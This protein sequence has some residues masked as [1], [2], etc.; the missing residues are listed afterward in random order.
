MRSRPEPSNLQALLSKPA[1]RYGLLPTV[2]ASADRAARE[3]AP[4]S[5]HSSD[6]L[7]FA[8]EAGGF[9]VFDLNL[10]AGGISGTPLF[11]DLIGLPGRDLNLTRE[12]WVATVHPED[13][14]AVVLAL[15][16]AIDSGAKYQCEYRTLLLNGEVR[17]LAGCAQVLLDDEGRPAHAIGT[18]CDI[19]ER[20]QLEEKL[21]YAT[22]SLNIAQTAAGLATF[23][24]NFGRNTR[25]CSEN[26]RTL[27]GIAPSTRLDD[28]DLLLSHVHP[29]D[30]ARL[31]SAPH[32]DDARRSDLSL[33]IPG[34]AR[35]CKPPLDRRE[36]HRDARQVR[37]DGADHGRHRRHQRLEA[38]RSG[39]GFR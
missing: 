23:D 29:D 8:Q 22:E 4:R 27:L 30:L 1:G 16:A 33:P 19:T 5:R 7:E 34:G 24:F 17:W 14:E 32:R 38:R 9:G 25:I 35:R 11:F 13:L 6:F 28:L 3:P 39:L 20:K 37:Q 12:E 2:P 31:R 18:L 36:S 21:R 15:S 26:F 10:A